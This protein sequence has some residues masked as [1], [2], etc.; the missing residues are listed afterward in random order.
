MLS[1]LLK[2]LIGFVFIFGVLLFGVGIL[3]S[4]LPV[5][6]EVRVWIGGI[7]DI[8]LIAAAIYWGF[9]RR[10][11]ATKKT[12]ARL[13]ER[14]TAAETPGDFMAAWA[15]M[16]AVMLSDVKK[17]PLPLTLASVEEIERDLKDIDMNTQFPD[18]E[19]AMKIVLA[20]GAFCGELIRSQ[21]GGSW[22]KE[23]PLQFSLVLPGAVKIHPLIVA[24]KFLTKDGDVSLARYCRT[25][26]AG[27]APSIDDGTL[28]AA[29]ES[30]KL[31]IQQRS[32]MPSGDERV[33]ALDALIAATVFA[34]WDHQAHPLPYTRASVQ[35]IERL[36]LTKPVLSVLKTDVYAQFIGAFLGECIRGELGGTWI[37]DG[38][39]GLWLLRVNDRLICNP[40]M[41]T[42][43]FF[44]DSDSLDGFYECSIALANDQGR[45][46]AGS[47]P[48]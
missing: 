27:N 11:S 35:V 46:D 1:L 41:K 28:S 7:I 8:G 4:L 25:H 47:P 34:A 30:I 36:F 32:E 31:L 44:T 24:A 37:Y 38:E 26:E 17:S 43:K 19:G 21:N 16:A 20:V 22:E 39:A 10:N 12:M 33:I 14:I 48:H 29:L 23:G 9:V 40:I 18:P 6:P 5:D 2:A 42:L 13:N 3:V 45:Q 15:A